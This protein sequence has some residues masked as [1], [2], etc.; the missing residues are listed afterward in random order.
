MDTFPF[1]AATELSLQKFEQ[2]MSHAYI[3]GSFICTRSESNEKNNEYQITKH[4]E[5]HMTVML[6]YN[7]GGYLLSVVFLG[8]IESPDSK[9]TSRSN[10]GHNN[11][12]NTI[13]TNT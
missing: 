13:S 2:W 11:A 5:Y 3:T 9:R 4:Y 8:I 7:R 1:A 10:H 6:M 12:F